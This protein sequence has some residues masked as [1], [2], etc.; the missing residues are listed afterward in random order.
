MEKYYEIS[1][2]RPCELLDAEQFT[3]ALIRAGVD[4][5]AGYDWA[6]ED[7]QPI[8]LSEFDEHK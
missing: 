6:I 2:S 8:D 7:I 4:N 3:D 1:H 5:W